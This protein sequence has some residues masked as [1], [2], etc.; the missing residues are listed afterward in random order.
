MSAETKAKAWRS[1]N[2][3]TR[4]SATRTSGVTTAA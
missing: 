4:R 2:T 1:S 3:S